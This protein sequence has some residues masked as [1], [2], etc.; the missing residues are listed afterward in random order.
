MNATFDNGT[1]AGCGSVGDL[2]ENTL[3]ASL[4]DLIERVWSHGAAN[5]SSCAFW[6][7]LVAFC[8]A[9]QNEDAANQSND[10]NSLTPGMRAAQT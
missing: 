5:E 3:I 2:E 10:S 1:F 9:G 7:Y 6:A 4:C 8:R